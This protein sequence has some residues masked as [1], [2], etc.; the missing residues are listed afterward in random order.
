ML[1]YISAELYKLRQHKGLWIAVAVLLILET[2]MIHP[3]FWVIGLSRETMYA[4]LTFCLFLGLFFAPIFA[5]D[6]FDDQHGHATLKN[7]VVFGIPRSRIYL[8]KLLAA[9]LAGTA[10]AAVVVGWFQIITALASTPDYPEAV[11][12]LLG[13]MAQIILCHYLMWLSVLAFTFFCLMTLKSASAAIVTAYLVIFFGTPISL[14][15]AGEGSPLWYQLATDLFFAAPLRHLLMGSSSFPTV[16][17]RLADKNIVAY[18]ALIAVLW[19]GG[20]TAAGL[21]IFRRREIK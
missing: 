20:T 12:E 15:G 18:A 13:A 4:I 9:A 6:T 5:A 21:A 1:N 10:V 2:W 19:V 14:I 7:E 16:A 8:G 17:S 11:G 3:A